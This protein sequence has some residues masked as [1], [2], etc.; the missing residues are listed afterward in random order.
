V[1]AFV[2]V[3]LLGVALLTAELLLP[4]GGVLAVLGAAGLVAG[5]VLALDEDSAIGD[6]VG[7][8][9]ITLGVLSIVTF[10]FVGRKVLEAHRDEPVRTGAE[11]LVGATAQARTSLD[12]EGQVWIEGAL[13]AARLADGKDRA[14]VGDRVRVEAIEGLTLLVRPEAPST[15]PAEEGAS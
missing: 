2:V 14:N 10:F 8:G 12:P 15:G 11:E 13:W 1:D 9:L 6:Y 7:P 3:A 4:S 5:G